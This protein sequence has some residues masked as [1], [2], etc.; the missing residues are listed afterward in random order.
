LKSEEIMKTLKKVTVPSFTTV[1]DLLWSMSS[2]IRVHLMAMDLMLDPAFGRTGK[3][4]E[5]Y[6]ELVVVDE[7]ELGIDWAK[8][9]PSIL[10][11]VILAGRRLGLAPCFPEAVCQIRKEA[12]LEGDYLVVTEPL[13]FNDGRPGIFVLDERP[14][15]PIL[16]AGIATTPF[17]QSCRFIFM[18]PVTA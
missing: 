14:E 16:N 7:S 6:I 10:G 5:C 8:P 15:G 12:G 9:T 18:K 1:R 17:S 3:S 13:K 11:S 2:Y 4:A